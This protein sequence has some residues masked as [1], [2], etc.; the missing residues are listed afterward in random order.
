MKSAIFFLLFSVSFLGVL[1]GQKTLE[2]QWEGHITTGGIYSGEQLPMQIFFTIKGGRI[3]G[4]TY[5]TVGEG[6]TIQMDLVGRLFNDNSLQ[7][8]EVKYVGDGSNDYFPKFNRQYQLTWKRDLWDASLIGYWQE[9]TDKTF[10]NFRERGKIVLKKAKESG[11]WAF[12]DFNVAVP[13]AQ[14]Q[15]GHR[16]VN[17]LV[18]S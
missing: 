18:V 7:L 3:E 5:V 2:G 17:T 9:V 16:Q 1:T 14:E 13:E 6:E 4:R 12:L 11:V 10:N 8:E 15:C